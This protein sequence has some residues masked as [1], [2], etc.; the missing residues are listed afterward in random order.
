MKLLI[1]ESEKKSILK[2]YGLI[3]EQKTLNKILCDNSGC[4]GTYIGPE[5]DAN[6]DVAH[7]F[8]NKMSNSVGDK[9]KELFRNSEYSKVDLEN[10]VMTTEGMDMRGDVKYSVSIPFIKVSNPCDAYTSFDHVGGWGHTPELDRRKSELSKLLLPNDEFDVSD[11]IETPEGLQEYWIQWRNKDLQ[12]NCST[13]KKTPTQ[14]PII[15]RGTDYDTLKIN[16]KQQTKDLSIDWNS[17]KLDL[18][19]KTLEVNLGGLELI[20]LSLIWDNISE[21]NL[22]TRFNDLKK[23]NESDGFT[24]LRKNP[25]RH[26][27]YWFLL[28][29]ILK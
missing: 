7:Q 2:M 20:N 5:F 13:S 12:S 1:N 19:S 6:G 22:I 25:I 27:K 11:I 14:K 26:D 24:V 9:L 21:D 10:I 29:A 16:I 23:K 15:I 3:K 8:S 18:S 28:I 17:A 4:K